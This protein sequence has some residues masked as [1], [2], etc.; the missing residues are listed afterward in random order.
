MFLTS[1]VDWSGARARA[2]AR[3]GGVLPRSPFPRKLGTALL[4]LGRISQLFKVLIEH[5][6]SAGPVMS[7]LLFGDILR[8]GRKLASLPL[9]L[10]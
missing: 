1:T 10:C 2:R 7:F 8:V 9:F 5:L 3:A 4:R 6:F